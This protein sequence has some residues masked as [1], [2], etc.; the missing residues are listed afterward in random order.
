VAASL[1]CA[2]VVT[3]LAAPSAQA[4]D[5]WRFTGPV[6]Y[7]ESAAVADVPGAEKQCRDQDGQVTD[8]GVTV[9]LDVSSTRIWWANVGCQA[10][11]DV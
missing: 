8:S 7:S 1:F 2:A 9:G 6:R 4:A 5:D 10:K 11:R 3:A